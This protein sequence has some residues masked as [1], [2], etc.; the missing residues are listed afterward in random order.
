[1]LWHAF[2]VLVSFFAVIGLLQCVLGIMEFLSLW[3]VRSVQKIALQ[4][5]LAGDEVNAEYLLNT[6]SL[7]AGRLDIGTREAVLEIVDEGLSEQARRD[8]LEY[9]EKNPWVVFTAAE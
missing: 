9:C 8:V 1:M 4:I 6:L 5:S 2:W 7:K 3:R